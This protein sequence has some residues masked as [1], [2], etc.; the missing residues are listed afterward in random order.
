LNHESWEGAAEYKTSLL[1]VLLIGSAILFGMLFR[2]LGTYVEVHLF[3]ANPK[4]GSAVD[5]LRE[6]EAF[7]RTAY[8]KIPVGHRYIRL[9]LQGLFFELSIAG[10]FVSL[11]LGLVACRCVDLLSSD[12]VFTFTLASAS[13]SVACFALHAAEDSHAVLARTRHLLLG[14]LRAPNKKPRKVHDEQPRNPPTRFRCFAD[15]IFVALTAALCLVHARD[16]LAQSWPFAVGLFGLTI[17]RASRAR[18]KW[19]QR[20]EKTRIATGT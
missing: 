2:E 6:W 10:A 16:R 11:G 1:S 17:W 19:T 15:A 9:V 7:L 5:H 4:V 13:W 20:T 14:G 12:W 18:D 8:E 3:D